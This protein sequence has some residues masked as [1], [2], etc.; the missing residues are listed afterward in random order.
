MY[1][2]SA[3]VNFPIL[4][5]RIAN[6]NS[7]SDTRQEVSST[8]TVTLHL[9]DLN[10]YGM[11]PEVLVTASNGGNEPMGP[12][13][14]A[15]TIDPNRSNENIDDRNQPVSTVCTLLVTEQPLMIS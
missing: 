6:A 11:V 1:L 5:Y 9:R 8:R 10:A 2:C 4:E 7:I 12:L 13:A 3:I 15:S 14:T